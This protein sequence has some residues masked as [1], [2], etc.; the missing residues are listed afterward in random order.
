MKTA[1]DNKTDALMEFSRQENPHEFIGRCC[2]LLAMITSQDKKERDF[3]KIKIREMVLAGSKRIKDQRTAL[4]L[5]E[6]GERCD[7]RP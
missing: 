5:I 4:E 1:T 6:R 2:G 3:A 7:E